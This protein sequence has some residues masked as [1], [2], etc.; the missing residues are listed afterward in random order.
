M[1]SLHRIQWIDVAI[2]RG[3][4]PNVEAIQTQFEI[5]RRQAMRDIEY[6]RDSLGAPIAYCSK[7]KGYYYEDETFVVPSPQITESEQDILSYL[8]AHYDVLAKHSSRTEG[9]FAGIAALLTRIAGKQPGVSLLQIKQVQREGLIPF[10]AVVRIE[11]RSLDLQ[12]NIPTSLRS[13]YR[14]QKGESAMVFEYY[15]SH[16]F[17]PALLASGLPFVIEQPKWLKSKFIQHLDQMKQLH[18]G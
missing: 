16:E 17:I 15:D 14:G 11:M 8:A 1:A 9:T 4:F 7:N 13:I 6:M 5:S 10:Q 12:H 18:Y 2:R 3:K